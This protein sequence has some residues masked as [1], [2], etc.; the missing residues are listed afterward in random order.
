VPDITVNASGNFEI[1]PEPSSSNQQN[2]SSGC[3]MGISLLDANRSAKTESSQTNGVIASPSSFVALPFA[4]NLAARVLYFRR[5]SGGP[6]DVRITTTVT[7]AVTIPKVSGILLLEIDAAEQLTGIEVQG[8][9]EYEW[10][11]TGVVV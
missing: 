3:A 10:A 5:K 9:G 11:A 1:V 8:E 7:G 6:F 2:K 4:A